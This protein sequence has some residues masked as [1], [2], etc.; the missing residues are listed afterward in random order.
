MVFWKTPGNFLHHYKVI[1]DRITIYQFYSGTQ[2]KT[3]I[4]LRN[5]VSDRFSRHCALSQERGGTQQCGLCSKAE[6][7]NIKYNHVS[8]VNWTCN[9]RV[10]IQT[11]SHC[12]TT[13]SQY[14]LI[15]FV[16]FKKVY[17]KKMYMKICFIGMRYRWAHSTRL[18]TVP[19]HYLYIKQLEKA[20]CIYLFQ[21]KKSYKAYHRACGLAFR[22]TLPCAS[23]PRGGCGI[24]SYSDE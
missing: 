24:K 18:G 15:C 6:K 20:V 5:Q 1:W 10:Y 16:F 3:G 13:T 9:Y 17:I 7:C 8:S 22:G 2:H 12:T 14:S 23:N 11:L 4:N 21:Y 19:F